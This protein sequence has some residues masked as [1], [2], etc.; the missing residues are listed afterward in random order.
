MRLCLQTQTQI[1]PSRQRVSCLKLKMMDVMWTALLLFLCCCTIPVQAKRK[2]DFQSDN[3]YEVLGLSKSASSKQIKSAYRKLALQYH[4]DKVSEEDKEKAEGIFIRISEAYA[5]LSDDEKRKI[6][7]QYGKNGLAAHEAGHD[8]RTAG[9]GGGGGGGYNPF[10]NGGGGQQFHFQ[11]GGRRRGGGSAG[12]DPFKMFEDM[13]GSGGGGFGG[14]GSFQFQQGF[15]SGGGGFHQQQQQQ[16][17]RQRQ[18]QPDLFPKNESKVARLG[19][20]KFPNAK[21]KHLWLILFYTNQSQES[22]QMAPNLE[23]LAEQKTL[24]YK[25][26]AVD[27]GKSEREAAFCQTQLQG[28]SSPQVAM[29]V[30]GELHFYDGKSTTPK[31]LHAF[32]KQH[33]PKHLIQNINHVPQ[34]RD[35]LLSS[36]SN[37]HAAVLLL[38]EKYETSDLYCNL[39]YHFRATFTFGESRAKNL[40]M[41]QHIKGV[42]RYPVLVAFVPT[43]YG[44]ERYSDTHDLYRY[45]GAMQ[46]DEIIEWLDNIAKVLKYYKK[47]DEL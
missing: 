30:D 34:L 13:M 8:P 33:M 18:R 14:G 29:V 7:D 44:K 41:A 16:Q 19:K 15:G 28:K 38:S 23:K 25:L 10:G 26:G 31:A 45:T 22:R 36:T 17:Q 47:K 12:F 1:K 27:C 4:P 39:S 40:A 37:K 42:K 5:V 24:A 20:P 9:F 35:R 32:A 3:Y 43:G 2:Q 11:S 6:Y 21:S 46:A